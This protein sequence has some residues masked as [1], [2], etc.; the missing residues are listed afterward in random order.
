MAQNIFQ[1]NFRPSE[2][3]LDRV[4]N[5]T[6]DENIGAATPADLIEACGI[7]PDFFCAACV[8]C[9]D[10]LTLDNVCAGMD[11]AYG[12]G[13]FKYAWT[14]NVTDRGVYEASNDNDPDMHP[15]ARFGF[16]GRFF[17]YVYDYGVAAVVDRESGEFMVARFD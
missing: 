17:C 10:D 14:G 5:P 9:G 16:D 3:L 13:G 4:L 2:I 1:L 11:D 15:L 8:G 12:Y 7:I 6:R